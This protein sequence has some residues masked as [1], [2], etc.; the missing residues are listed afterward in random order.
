MLKEY[1]IKKEQELLDEKAKI[2]SVDYSA[3]ISKEVEDFKAKKAEEIAEFENQTKE[4][5]EKIIVADKSKIDC[6]LEFV[7]GELEKLEA[8]ESCEDSVVETESVQGSE[9]GIE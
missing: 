8:E 1:F 6:Y 7:R 2:E 4:K 9:A 5:Y 3:E